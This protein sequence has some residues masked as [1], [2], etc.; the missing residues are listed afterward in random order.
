MKRKEFCFSQY[1]PLRKMVRKTEESKGG[2]FATQGF[3]IPKSYWQQE[4]SRKE[5]GMVMFRI[6][7]LL[8]II[9]ALFYA[10]FRMIPFTV[11]FGYY[12][13]QYCIE[14]LCEKKKHS[15]ERQFHD[16]LQ[17]LEAHLNVGYSMENSIKETKRDLLMLYKNSDA[18]VKEFTYMSRQLNLNVT[19]EQVWK[20][21]ASRVNIPSV[22]NFVIVL[23]QAKRSGGDSIS[24]IKATIHRLSERAEIKEEIETI[25]A[26]RRLEFQ[27]MT[28]IPFGIIAYMK[29]SFP[30]FMNVLYGGLFGKCFMSVCLGIYFFAWRLGGHIVEIEV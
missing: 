8:S 27:I 24:I 14:K 25:I 20:D 6:I 17:T 11:P 26:A 29:I 21:F 16:A 7:F 1:L 28:I 12:Y 10:D 9:V 5:K 22:D 4:I 23:I 15:F 19:V 13:Y 2:G 18:I 30:E 3:A